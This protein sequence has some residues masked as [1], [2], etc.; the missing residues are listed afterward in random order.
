V[1]VDRLAVPVNAR[2]EFEK[3]CALSS[4]KAMSAEQHLS[5]AVEFYP[6][7]AM[8]WLLL[9]QIQLTES[10]NAEAATSCRQALEVDAGYLPPYVCLAMLEAAANHWSLVADL[11]NLVLEQ[12]PVTASGAYYYNALA[13]Y[14]LHQF[15]AAEKSALQ[16]VEDSGENQRPE[17]HYLLAKIFEAEDNRVSEAAELRRFLKLAPHSSVAVRVKVA[18]KQIEDK[19]SASSLPAAPKPAAGSK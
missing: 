5:K 15:S 14:H 12:H 7:Y 11:T 3:A 17:V 18:L 16:A 2:K 8:A 1:N 9:G 6:K 4:S 19:D 10:K 13:N